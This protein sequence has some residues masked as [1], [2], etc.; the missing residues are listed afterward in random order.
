[1]KA[2]LRVRCANASQDLLANFFIVFFIV[3]RSWKR[4]QPPLNRIEYPVT[5]SKVSG[6]VQRSATAATTL[7]SFVRLPLK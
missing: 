4:A 7:T 3:R 2:S 5:F 1:L 6:I